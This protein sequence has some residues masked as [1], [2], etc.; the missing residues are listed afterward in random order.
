MFSAASSICSVSDRAM[1]AAFVMQYRP[2]DTGSS[3]PM[4]AVLTM[5][6]PSPWARIRGRNACNPWPTPLM[7]TSMTQSQ[8]ACLA[9]ATGPARPIPA[10][11]TS[12]CTRPKRRS[13]SSAARQT[14]S[15]SVTSS[16]V[17][18]TSR[19]WEANSAADS[20][21]CCRRRPV[22]TTFMPA[23]AKARAMPRPIP[24]DPPVTNATLPS[25]SCT[26]PS[27][28]P[29][30]RRR[31]GAE[32]QKPGRV[33]LHDQR[34]H[35][36]LDVQLLEIPDPPVGGEGREIRAEEHLVA[37][38]AVGVLHQQGREVLRRPAGQVDVDARLVGRDRQ[39][40]VL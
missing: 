12:T 20:S 17:A 21:R 37:Q 33:L 16:C 7:F 14:A 31:G 9:C 5:W 11:F 29:P 15:L 4:D 25:T 23:R 8:S 24:L 13:V 18:C 40:L 28:L 36:G 22:M 39:S 6:P 3:P 27:A 19:P 34:A 2:A 32:T 26:A 35:L 38:Q 1:I 30:R 10:L